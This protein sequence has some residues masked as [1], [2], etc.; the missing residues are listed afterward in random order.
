MGA[1][2]SRLLGF[3]PRYPHF[4]AFKEVAPGFWNLRAPFFVLG[5]T[6]NIGT[7]MS[8]VELAPN[9]F[10]AIDCCP[11]T[12]SA[13]TEL[14]ELT[15]GGELLVAVLTTHPF[16]TKAIGTF[17]ASYPSSAERKWYGCPRHL[18][19]VTRD[20]NDRPIDWAG[21]LNNCSVRRKFEPVMLMSI[22][23]GAEFVNPVPPTRN[24]LSTVLVLHVPSKVVHV[25][26][27]INWIEGP[28]LLMRLAGFSDRTLHFHPSLTSV[29]LQP[30]QQAPLQ[31]REWVRA[32]LVDGWD[33][34]HLVSAHNGVLIGNA[35]SK[36]AALLAKTDDTLRKLSIKNAQADAE[37]RASAAWDGPAA[38]VGQAESQAGQAS[39][40]TCS[41]CWSDVDI[42][43]G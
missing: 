17:H 19:K 4:K 9:A 1:T 11:L 20:A 40:V 31:F 6:L 32:T 16:H 26:D 3:T 23:D 29:G 42:D 10:A 36:V 21:D 37:R 15:S 27:C 22:P 28:G 13:A 33:F 18:A 41:D 7:Q 35:K 5:G 30:T 34:E 38:L 24:H 2:K 14:N 43:C 8:I 39:A 12:A 25:D